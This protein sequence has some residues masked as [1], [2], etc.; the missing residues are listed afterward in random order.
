MNQT[1]KT[2]ISSF[3]ASHSLCIL[4]FMQQASAQN[5]Y[6][7]ADK[8]ILAGRGI[9]NNEFELHNGTRGVLGALVNV[10]GGVTQFKLVVDTSWA[11]NDST[12]RY[13]RTNGGTYD[14]T[15]HSSGSGGGITVE[16]DPVAICS[17]NNHHHRQQ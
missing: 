12:T 4:F 5:S 3:V 10:G 15:I 16:S 6:I 1:I 17:K 9:G 11:L 7:Y 8:T 14:I 13:H 2:F